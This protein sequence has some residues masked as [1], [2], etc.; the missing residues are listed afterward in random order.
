MLSQIGKKEKF[1]R[2]GLDPE[3]E[4]DL[5]GNISIFLPKAGILTVTNGILTPDANEFR[6]FE[7]GDLLDEKLIKALEISTDVDKTYIVIVRLE[8]DFVEI[9]D[10]E[11]RSLGQIG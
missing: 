9:A 8:N 7:Y 4:D 1:G 3:D 5:K 11:N 2:K 10:K 6:Q